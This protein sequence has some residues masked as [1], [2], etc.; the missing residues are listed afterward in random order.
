MWKPRRPTKI[1]IRASSTHFTQASAAKVDC[2]R[3]L[4][5]Y[6]LLWS[7][8]GLW[9]VDARLTSALLTPMWRH[10]ELQGGFGFGPQT[11]ADSAWK[12]QRRSKFV[13]LCALRTS[14]RSENGMRTSSKRPKLPE[15]SRSEAQSRDPSLYACARGPFGPAG[16]GS[17]RG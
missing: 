3:P 4:A 15:E 14:K 8:L 6:M 17:F 9:D 1:V 7:P 12:R 13:I 10:R 5:K 11:I 2:A 16:L